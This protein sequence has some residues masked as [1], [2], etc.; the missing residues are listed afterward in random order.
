ML[1]ES[2]DRNARRLT[3]TNVSAAW[4]ISEGKESKQLEESS[5]QWGDIE[6]Q[7]LYRGK[8]GT[9]WKECV[10]SR[11]QTIASAYAFVYFVKQ[12]KISF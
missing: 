4:F 10:H 9:L 12:I 5:L 8:W 2:K 6:G 1:V 7:S 11:S 3:Q